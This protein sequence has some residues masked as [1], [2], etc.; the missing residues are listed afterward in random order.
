MIEPRIKSWG[1]E[2]SDQQNFHL[3]Y[4]RVE[5]LKKVRLTTHSIKWGNIIADLLGTTIKENDTFK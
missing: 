1:W 4:L 2:N 5:L 3:P